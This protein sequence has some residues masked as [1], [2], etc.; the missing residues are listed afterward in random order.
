MLSKL[1]TS[2]ITII[3]SFLLLAAGLVA[4]VTLIR[5]PQILF[6]EAAEVQC[7][8]TTGPFDLYC[9]WDA[10]AGTIPT[11]GVKYN[12]LVQDDSGGIHGSGQGISETYGS[13]TGYPDITYTCKVSAYSEKD[14]KRVSGLAESSPFSC[15]APTPTPTSPPA[16]KSYQLDIYNPAPGHWQEGETTGKWTCW[17]AIDTDGKTNVSGGPN[18]SLDTFIC[19]Y[20][21][22][23]SASVNS[24]SAGY[25]NREGTNQ[26]LRWQT[27]RCT[28]AQTRYVNNVPVCENSILTGD[29]QDVAPHSTLICTWDN[30]ATTSTPT[31]STAPLGAISGTVTVNGTVPSGKYLKIHACDVRPNKGLNCE[32]DGGY[33]LLSGTGPYSISNVPAGRRGVVL[34]GSYYDSNGGYI[35]DIPNNSITAPN[36]PEPGNYPRDCILNVPAGGTV[37]QDFTITIPVEE[38]QTGTISGTVTVNNS[39]NRPVDL[40]GIQKC[41]I[42]NDGSF[43]ECGGAAHLPASGGNYSFNATNGQK[44]SVEAFAHLTDTGDSYPW[45]VTPDQIVIAPASGINFTIT[46]PAAE[47]PQTGT[48][49]GTVTV[50]ANGVPYTTVS[51]IFDDSLAYHAYFGAQ[52]TDD[53]E[54]PYTITG[55][56]EGDTHT[57]FAHVSRQQSGLG[58]L[59]VS[60][61]D[62][63]CPTAPRG[64]SNRYC[65]VTVSAVQDFTLTIPAGTPAPPTSTPRAPAEGTPADISGADGVPDG[66]VDAAD[67]SILMSNWGVPFGFNPAADL[68]NDGKVDALDASLLIQGWS[69][70]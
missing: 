23:G 54:F 52:R 26:N 67:A 69:G 39:H 30:P 61:H 65:V 1:F 58:Y 41:K 16:I 10:P 62:R 44:Y 55:L 13:F 2:R 19:H 11:D 49:S 21:N 66:V 15:T 63:D 9:A 37:T 56:R 34:W 42:Q 36:C 27:N 5:Y 4:G 3:L 60:D 48:I 38:P 31:C 50:N 18:Q 35:E 22:S 24:L 29:V 40:V 59:A 68:N 6:P 51:V 14:C 46:I 70:K 43:Y 33:D 45:I 20:N 12:F 7:P 64:G 25:L 53:A 57:L 8:A 32:R 47:E 28:Q 17:S